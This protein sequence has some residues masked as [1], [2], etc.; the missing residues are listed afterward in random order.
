[1]DTISDL[2]ERWNPDERQLFWLDDAFGAT[3]FDRFLA[4]NWTASSQRVVS[5]IQ[6]GNMFVVTSR[7]YVFRHAYGYLKPGSFPLFK[8]A[9]V[10]VNVSDLGLEERRQILYNHLRHGRQPRDFLA[11][12][13]P[14][15]EMAAAHQGF[16]PELARRLGDPIFTKRV[17][18]ASPGR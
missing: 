11:S 8:E 17:F 7:D 3:Q 6:A 1:M 9:Q 15:L 18:P 14:N 16:S 5:A 10:V 12:A 4:S 13:M 2:Q